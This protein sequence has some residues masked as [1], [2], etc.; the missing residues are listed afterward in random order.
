M[1]LRFKEDESVGI[2][3]LFDGEKQLTRIYKTN[4]NDEAD[5]N[6]VYQLHIWPNELDAN[7]ELNEEHSIAVV[8]LYSS[9]FPD[10]LDFFTIHGG[11]SYLHIQSKADYIN[12]TIKYRNNLGTWN[13]PF[14]A[15]EFCQYFVENF[16]HDE[17]CALSE[18]H[19]GI[20]FSFMMSKNE[21]ELKII[22]KIEILNNLFE[23]SKNDSIEALTHS[24]S[25]E[26][27]IRMFDF[28]SDYANICSQY[29]MWFGEF[30]KNLGI[31]ADVSTENKDGKTSLTVSPA[32][33]GEMLEQIEELFHTYLSLP[34]VKVLPPEQDISPQNLHAYQTAIFQV[35]HL[36]TQIQMKDAAIASYQATNTTLS[37]RV[38][39]Q[40]GKLILLESLQEKEKWN[41]VPFTL[42]SLEV[43]D[44]PTKKCTLKF[45]P[46]VLYNKLSKNK[47]N[48]QDEDDE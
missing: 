38:E 21:T 25:K 9:N 33:N 14:S 45:E 31:E 29:L 8:N 37:E 48:E 1:D 42:G 10:K 24:K 13:H 4:E 36:G 30:L 34:Y 19:H 5:K 17:F 16:T 46:A 39:H 2:L 11:T 6:G 23:K 32:E 40:A 22:D 41:K 15:I 43:K 44:F 47:K 27:F 26:L 20:N 3:R 18:S 12:V 35:Q 28:P 7:K